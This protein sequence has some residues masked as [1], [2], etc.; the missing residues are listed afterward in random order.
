MMGAA[1]RGPTVHTSAPLSRR[2]GGACRESGIGAARVARSAAHTSC[3]DIDYGGV[4]RG[5]R[6]NIFLLNGR[7][8]SSIDEQTR[9]AYY[10]S[11]CGGERAQC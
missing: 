10:A 11:V 9:N 2:T 1:Y 4:T 5:K 7:L 3:L 6:Y 8:C